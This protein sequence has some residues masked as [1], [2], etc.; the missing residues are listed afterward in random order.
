M[1]EAVSG[2][3]N[4]LVTK[5]L[6]VHVG[7][8]EFRVKALDL[9]LGILVDLLV[10]K[11]TLESNLACIVL[12]VDEALGILVKSD[13]LLHPGYLVLGLEL[14]LLESVVLLDLLDFEL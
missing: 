14:L 3:L 7:L 12:L 2:E 8:V 11:A 1:L 9:V 4:G 6:L 5:H 10:L 13:S